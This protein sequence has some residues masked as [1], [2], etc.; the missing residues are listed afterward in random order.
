MPIIA[1][2]DNA[3]VS[4]RM[5]KS[6]PTV[7]ITNTRWKTTFVSMRETFKVLILLNKIMCS[8][9][10]KKYTKC[11]KFFLNLYTNHFMIR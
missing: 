7:A 4:T 6:E 9:N 2:D 10:R 8:E 11:M 3:G 5:T 1:A